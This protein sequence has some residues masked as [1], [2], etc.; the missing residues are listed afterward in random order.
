[1]PNIEI[2]LTDDQLVTFNDGKLIIIEKAP[3][4]EAEATFEFHM[5]A[6]T[7]PRKR[8]AK[9]RPRALSLMS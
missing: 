1:M 3:K 9:R 6:E 5:P 4:A 7:S 2:T 8:R